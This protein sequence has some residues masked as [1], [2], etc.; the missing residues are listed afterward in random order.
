MAA[1]RSNKKGVGCRVPGVGLAAV[2]VLLFFLIPGTRN[3][4][5]AFPQQASLTGKYALTGKFSTA[6]SSANILF[7]DNFESDDT[8]LVPT[9]DYSNSSSI[10]LNTDANYVHGGSKSGRFHYVLAAGDPASQ[11]SNRWVS[12][13]FTSPTHDDVHVGGWVY[14]KTPEVGQDSYAVQRKLMWFCDATG[15]N[16]NSWTWETVLTT[17]TGYGGTSYTD[18]LYPTIVQSN[19]A[20]CGG[21]GDTW[22]LSDYFSWNAWHFIEFE[23]KLNTPSTHDGTIRLWVDGSLWY[24][25]TS[26]Y[27]RGTCS[28]NMT[29][30]SIGRQTNRT[31]S[32]AIDEYRYWDDVTIADGYIGP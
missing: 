17:W 2:L 23:V 26:A 21:S 11:D 7:S 15:A 32:E 8:D 3:P 27:P 1:S 14:F 13:V 29:F 31:H 28:S 20:N 16:Q 10:D 9:W 25:N 30:F 19:A 22:Y 5:S 4:A 12:K 18:R 6:S 24:E